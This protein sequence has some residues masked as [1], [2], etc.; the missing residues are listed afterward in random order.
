MNGVQPV[1]WALIAPVLAP[2]IAAVLV[3]VL[4][5]VLPRA[6]LAATGPTVLDVVAGAGLLGGILAL[7]P[8]AGDERGTFCTNGDPPGCSYAVEP[9]TSGLQLVI[10]LAAGV[11][12]LLAIGQRVQP[13]RAEHHLLLL[14]ATAGA[15]AV[16]GARDLATVLVALE[17]ASLPVVGLVALRRD[18]RGAE[19]ALKLLLTSVVSVALLVLGIA[20]L[21]AASGTV[22]LGPLGGAGPIAPLA[23]DA[24]ALAGLGVV[25]AVTGIAFKVSVV[26][27]QLW[28]PDTYAGAPLPVA[29]FLAAV[30]KAAGLAGLVVVLAAGA[31]L[32]G[33]TWT[34]VMAVLAGLTMTVG[35][36]VALRQTGA[37]RLL[38]WSTVAQAG[39]VV[40]PLAGAGRDGHA[41]AAAAGAA[42]AYL[43]AY[44]VASLLAF[45]V[46]AVVS[47]STPDGE[48][49]ELSAYAGLARRRPVLGAALG[50]AL[51][52]LAGLPPG[53]VGLV[54]KVVAL[55]PVV[56]DGFWILA[57]VAVVNVA[58]GIAVYLRWGVL[59]VAEP[60]TEAGMAAGTEAGPAGAA[61]MEAGTGAAGRDGPV[62]ASRPEL[63]ALVTAGF[64]AVLLS[65]APQLVAVLTTGL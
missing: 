45:A 11:C 1:D 6:A 8:L 4:D 32:L 31:P 30:S 42:I 62:R 25:F 28:T 54:A 12:L 38:A 56:A 27:F 21:Y 5:A 49:H 18:R 9:V 22:Y 39:W 7:L 51:V 24:R 3:L 50:F 29:A 53:V 48:R 40:L 44:V 20:M 61:W 10:L 65:V 58:L 46:V 47:R 36:L 43:A 19:A 60:G 41:S 63:A 34:P 23:P 13:P 2:A 15:V 37:I 52:A 64:A 26:P 14:A 33:A 55:R 57:A 59:L 17:T 35:N 16:A